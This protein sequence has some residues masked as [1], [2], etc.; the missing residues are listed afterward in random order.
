MTALTSLNLQPQL[1][2]FQFRAT[3]EPVP[4]PPAPEPPAPEPPTPPAPEPID[5]G[6]IDCAKK[7]SLLP[8]LNT[9]VLATVVTGLIASSMTG[10]P[11]SA[12]ISM[13]FNE[14]PGNLTYSFNPNSPEALVTGSG[15]LGGVAYSENWSINQ[16]TGA[17]SV[18]AKLGETD[19]QFN[20][21][22][23]EDGGMRISGNIGQLAVDQ[24]LFAVESDQ[25]DRN[26][27]VVDGTIGGSRF[28]QELT[29]TEEGGECGQDPK[30]MLNVS[31][32]VGTS[33]LTQVT[34]LSQ[35]ETGMG[36]DAGGNL[37][38]VA[39]TMNASLVVSQP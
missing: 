1:R 31:G 39:F 12:T 34:A 15:D 35:H 20:L 14:T 17:L 21:S 38:G 29:V 9:S 8:T 33:D 16:E 32:Y 5:F 2:A 19:M 7:A 28:H 10:A 25:E 24:S 23:S 37:A 3:E 13:L 30:Q 22:E 26:R 6:S 18:T 4:E 36:A 27:V 11:A